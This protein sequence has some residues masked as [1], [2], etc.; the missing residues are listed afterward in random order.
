MLLFFGDQNGTMLLKVFEGLELVWV[1]A[2]NGYPYLQQFFYRVQFGVGFFFS[3]KDTVSYV[4]GL[5]QVCE[6]YSQDQ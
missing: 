1:V 4:S 2:R 5:F 6:G 3:H